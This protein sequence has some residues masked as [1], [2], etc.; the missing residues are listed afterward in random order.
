MKNT[1][2]LVKNY[3]LK[4]LN[5]YIRHNKKELDKLIS[6]KF[7]EYGSSGR[8]YKYNDIINQLLESKDEQLKYKIIEIDTRNL[9]KNIIQVLY[10]IETEMEEKII[11]NRNSIWEKED[12]NWKI[13]FHQGTIVNKTNV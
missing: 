5:K 10:I 11:T 2:E 4:L 6:K 3:E 13:I 8:I 1:H 9:S 12:D 7:I